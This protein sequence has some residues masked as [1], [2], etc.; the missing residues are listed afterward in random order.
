VP[1]GDFSRPTG[2]RKPVKVK[3]K[4][5]KPARP[6]A[7][8]DRLP[9]KKGGKPTPVKATVVKPLKRKI[10]VA[11][12]ERAGKDVKS[13]AD[14]GRAQ[15]FLKKH[16]EILHPRKTEHHGGLLG[17]VTGAAGK[18]AP[19]GAAAYAPAITATLA[20]IDKATGAHTRKTAAKF[21]G[22]AGRDTAELAVT[23]PSSVAK[24]ASTAVH[25]PE[26]VPGLLAQPYKDFLKHPGKTAFEHPVSTAL[27][28]APGVKLPGRAVGRVARAAGK[29]SLER[30]AATLP[31]TALKETRTGSRDAVVRKVQARKDRKN[32]HPKMSDEQVQRRVDEFFDAGQQ[33]K[34]RVEAAASKQAKQRTKG[35]PKAVRRQETQEHLEGARGGAKRQVDRK[36]AEE[37]G[38]TWQIEPKSGAIVKP[39]TATKGVLHKD[40]AHADK[41]V[42]RV[43]F[44]ATVK[45]VNGKF[46]VVPKV[47]AE[48]L[49]KHQKVGSSPAI[50]AIAMRAAGRTFRGAVLPLSP[51]WLAGQATEAGVRAAIGGAGP[52]S[53]LRMRRVVKAM[54][55]QQPGSGKALLARTSAG[56]HFGLT[57]TA[58]EFAQGK[59]LAEE[60]AP[61]ANTS[62]GKAATGATRL[63][64]T[65]PMRAVRKGWNRYTHLVFDTVNGAFEQTARTAMAGKALKNGPL[66]ERHIIGLSD[67]AVADAAKGLHATENQVELGR[68]VDRMYGAYAKFSPSKRETLLHTTPF[69]P[70]YSN[71]VTF[72]VK[73]LP[74]DHPVITALIADVQQVEK[75]WRKAH[76]LSF[77]GKDRVPSFLLGSYPKKSGAHL[78]LSKYAPF[79]AFNDPTGSIADL[80]LPQYLGIR[81]NLKGKDWT[82]KDIKGNVE[83]N[84]ALTALETHVPGVS[85]VGK[86]TGLSGRYVRKTGEKSVV[87]GKSLLPAVRTQLDP[88]RSFPAKKGAGKTTATGK[89]QTGK[90]S[91][92]KLATG[93]L[94]TR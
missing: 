63:G 35:K 57:G 37:F 2:G 15:A 73:V 91:T 48:R 69:W 47:A 6:P 21:V 71:A 30:P 67:K 76:G 28:L 84:A 56:G 55:K 80:A 89:V 25:D 5:T 44:D 13:D 85:Q 16:P 46:A 24:L 58:R 90:L 12:R 62:L 81:D 26:K 7:M 32:P 88:F 20:G 74:A 33:H 83:L 49:T 72:L 8:L 18:V 54:E 93:R 68:A 51:R 19:I 42:E 10:E 22:N 50:G 38:S 45:E 39:K 59:S 86:I 43:P 94:S 75:D 29:Q 66:M 36:F 27:M 11:S 41:I 52:T 60:F 70:W 3:P 40:R 79:G 78:P 53:Y 31:G 23:T 65:A 82:G 9:Q 17:V 61:H 77:F 34:R 14:R 64:D 1:S 4:V 87:Q 92:G